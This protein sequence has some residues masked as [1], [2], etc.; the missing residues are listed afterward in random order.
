MFCPDINDLNL[1]C[2]SCQLNYKTRADYRVHLRAVHKMKLTPLL[3]KAVFDPTISVNDTSDPKNAG[4]VIC[5]RRYCS[6]PTY[7][8]HMRNIHKNDG[9]ESAHNLNTKTN[10]NIQPDPNDPNFYCAACKKPYLSQQTYRRHIHTK[11]QNVKVERVRFLPAISP[12]VLEM[13]AGG[14]NNTR[15]KI[16]DRDHNT[17]ST[18]LDHM[19]RTHKNGKRDP[20][21]P[22]RAYKAYVD[23]SVIPT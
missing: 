13:D 21:P 15:C 5:K 6:R 1:F 4:C 23:I 8:R 20:V 14:R 3:K 7:L 17:R 9:N 16:C 22:R 2:K 19:R 18:Y 12:L 11:H 10:H